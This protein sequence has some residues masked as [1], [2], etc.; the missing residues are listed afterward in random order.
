MATDTE[1]RN[2]VLKMFYDERGKGFRGPF[3]SEA[4]AASLTQ[5]EI[6]R[7]SEQ[8][9]QLGLI[10]WKG[11][12]GAYEGMGKLTVYGSQ[13]MEGVKPAPAGIAVHATTI[14]GSNN[15][16]GNQNVQGVNITIRDLNAAINASDASQEAKAEAKGLLDTFLDNPVVKLIMAKFGAPSS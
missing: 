3:H 5:D 7:G 2:G 6:L 4:L 8:L 11:L 10:E 14:H 16:V 12:P 1:A 13:V 15:I 9:A